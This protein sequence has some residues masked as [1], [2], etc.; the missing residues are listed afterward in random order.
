MAST[1]EAAQAIDLRTRHGDGLDARRNCS[2][3]GAG[4]ST[5][6]ADPSTALAR[7]SNA[8]SS[9]RLA[10]HVAHCER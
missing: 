5:G 1:I 4:R 3:G 7:S 10:R 8:R 9:A 2:N 6:R